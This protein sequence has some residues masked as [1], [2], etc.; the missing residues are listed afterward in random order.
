MAR[1]VKIPMLHTSIFFREPEMWAKLEK[2]IMQRYSKYTKFQVLDLGCSWGAEAYSLAYTLHKLGYN[3]HITA[4]DQNP[5]V[6][7]YASKG[8]FKFDSNLRRVYRE[9]DIFIQEGD[10]VIQG[11]V[12][13]DVYRQKI[14]FSV[15]DITTS[16]FWKTLR[17]NTFHLVVIRYVLI[18]IP[19]EKIPF[20]LDNIYQILTPQGLLF[21]GRSEKIEKYSSNFKKIERGIYEPLRY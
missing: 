21:L 11:F 17:R 1:R 15:A 6:V 19:T 12:V 14:S 10:G 9:T 20:I 3:Y 2:L 5:E 7:N 8:V 13:N 18:H 16:T 4:V